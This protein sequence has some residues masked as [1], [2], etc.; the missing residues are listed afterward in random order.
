MEDCHYWD[1]RTVSGLV[2]GHFFAK[3][4][5][6]AF[7]VWHTLTNCQKHNDL[8]TAVLSIKKVWQSPTVEPHTQHGFNQAS[9]GSVLSRHLFLAPAQNPA[10]P[11]PVSQSIWLPDTVGTKPFVTQ[12]QWVLWFQMFS[13]ASSWLLQS[14]RIGFGFAMILEKPLVKQWP[15]PIRLCAAVSQ[16]HKC[17]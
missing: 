4:H 7:N 14:S 3:A 2:P 10:A 15:V 11:I 13:R 17:D 1:G 5:F 9:S 6:E 8:Q 16:L 12:I